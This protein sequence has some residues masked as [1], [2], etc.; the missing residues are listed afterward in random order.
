MDSSPPNVEKKKPRRSRKD[1]DDRNFICRYCDKSYL[2]N[3]ALY[4]HV[5]N[6]H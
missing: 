2:S 1:M 5:K 3:A 4:T 6:K